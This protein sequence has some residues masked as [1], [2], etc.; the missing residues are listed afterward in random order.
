MITTPVGM[1]F[2]SVNFGGEFTFP[3]HFL[4]SYYLRRISCST[5]NGCANADVTGKR[6]RLFLGLLLPSWLM[7]SCFCISMLHGRRTR[8]N[9][10]PRQRRRKGKRL[11]RQ[12]GCLVYVRKALHGY[13]NCASS[14]G[15]PLRWYVCPVMRIKICDWYPYNRHFRMLKLQRSVSWGPTKYYVQSMLNNCAWENAS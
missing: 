1:Y 4:L 13:D 3:L 5:C 10:K 15:A 9:E 6:A 14:C 11:S 2:V 8:R 7:L 12:A